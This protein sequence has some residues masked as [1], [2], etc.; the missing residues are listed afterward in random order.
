MGTS[1]KTP[2]FFGNNPQK[3]AVSY[4]FGF[5]SVCAVFFRFKRCT[6]ANRSEPPPKHFVLETPPQCSLKKIQPSIVLVK[7]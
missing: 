7:K 4:G 2:K 1:Y 3:N 5:Y 6:I